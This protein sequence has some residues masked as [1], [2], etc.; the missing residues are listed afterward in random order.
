L[1]VTYYTLINKPCFDG[2]VLYPE[3][4]KKTKP[5]TT[6]FF[7]LDYTDNLESMT[8]RHKTVPIN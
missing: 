4:R 5:K 8:S 7:Q 1:H 3:F 2:A 6:H